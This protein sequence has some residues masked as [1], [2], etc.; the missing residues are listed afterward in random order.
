MIT[1][2]A[3]RFAIYHPIKNYIKRRN[4]VLN[5]TKRFLKKK[6]IRLQGNSCKVKINAK[7]LDDCTICCDSLEHN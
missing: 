3:F 2:T 1:F 6:T 5:K 4:S 7:K